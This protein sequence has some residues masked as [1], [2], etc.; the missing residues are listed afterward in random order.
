MFSTVGSNGSDST[1]KT[2]AN[3]LTKVC[4]KLRLGGKIGKF[5]AV[6]SCV[7]SFVRCLGRPALWVPVGII[8]VIFLF[9]LF[10]LL[11]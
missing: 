11:S 9:L 6:R 7:S 1:M 10:L 3:L 4:C 2:L 8:P 5:R